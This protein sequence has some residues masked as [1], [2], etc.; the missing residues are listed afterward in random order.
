MATNTAVNQEYTKGLS[1]WKH[2][3][4]RSYILRKKKEVN[5]YELAAAKQ[6]LQEI[7][8]REYELTRKGRKTSARYRGA[9]HKP[10]LT[11]VPV[12]PTSSS[13]ESEQVIVKPTSEGKESNR[14]RKKKTNMSALTEHSVSNGSESKL[15]MQKEQGENDLQ[16]QANKDTIL[17]QK[18]TSKATNE[19]SWGGDYDLP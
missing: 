17:E 4:I 13:Q 11:I 16:S 12:S 1:L 19:D 18:I 15:D 3:I 10:T 9:N 8:D 5:I 2:R 14:K 7:V 6:H